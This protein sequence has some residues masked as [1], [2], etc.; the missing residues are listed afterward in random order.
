MCESLLDVQW[1]CLDNFPVN[2]RVEVAETEAARWGAAA[3]TAILPRWLSLAW[4]CSRDSTEGLK[5][6]AGEIWQPED[7]WQN[8]LLTNFVSVQKETE[9][10]QINRAVMGHDSN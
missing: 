8:G 9:T 3:S 2:T 4:L 10:G 1:S 6:R 7:S 5:A